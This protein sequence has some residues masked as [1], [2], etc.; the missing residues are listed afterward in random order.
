MI[1]FFNKKKIIK[2]NNKKKKKKKRRRRKTKRVFKKARAIFESIYN[3]EYHQENFKINELIVFVWDY[4]SVGILFWHLKYTSAFVF[5][6]WCDCT[7]SVD[8]GANGRTK[9]RTDGRAGGRTG[10]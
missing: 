5:A 7:K 2:I 1:D 3:N 6:S 10:V 4:R 9:D 8:E